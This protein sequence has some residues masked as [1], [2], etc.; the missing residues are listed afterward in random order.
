LPPTFAPQNLEAYNLL[1]ENYN[2]K[3]KKTKT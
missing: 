3:L 2:E 1:T